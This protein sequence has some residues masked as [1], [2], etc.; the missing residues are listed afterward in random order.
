MTIATAMC[1]SFKT[2]ILGAGH[3]FQAAPGSAPTGN[4]SSGSP[5]IS[6]VSSLAGIVVGMS[7]SGTGI[8]ANTTVI[9]MPTTTSITMSANATATNTGVTLTLAGDNFFM[10]LIKSGMTG[11][12]SATTANYSAVTGNGDEVSSA[13]TNYTTGGL[14]LG[15]VSPTNDGTSIAWVSFSPN[16]SWSNATFSTAGCIIY[17]NSARMSGTTGRAVSVHDFGGVQSVSSGNLTI[18]IPSA[19]NS[20][21]IL[22]LA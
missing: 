21:A 13:G 10:A 15:N 9:A 20:S 16:P 5:T 22:R 19:N 6:S 14:S 12:Y 7:I 8:P 17:N 2:E 1:V 18:L 3:C 4:L 11:N